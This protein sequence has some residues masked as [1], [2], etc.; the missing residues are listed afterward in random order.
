MRRSAIAFVLTMILS[1]FPINEALAKTYAAIAVVWGQ[2]RDFHGVGTGS[3]RA[4]A[5]KAALAACRNGRCKIATNYGPGQCIF[6]VLGERQVWWNDRLFS[7]RERKYVI[8]QCRKEDSNCRV[9]YS[10]CLPE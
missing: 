5:R 1:A 4:T 10:K 6:V 8:A 3:T 7:A 2:G 9:I